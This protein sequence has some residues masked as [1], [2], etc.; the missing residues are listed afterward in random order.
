ML[1]F[2]IGVPMVIFAVSAVY[3]AFSFPGIA[4]VVQRVDDWQGQ[5]REVPA[6]YTRHE[7]WLIVKRY[8]ELYRANQLGGQAR[9]P[10]I[11]VVLWYL[12]HGSF[13]FLL[14]AA[15]AGKLFFRG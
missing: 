15:V 4:E 8:V 7:A 13:V 10:R 9:D 6:F 11:P 12:A 2:L 1:D 14:V 3:F 5:G